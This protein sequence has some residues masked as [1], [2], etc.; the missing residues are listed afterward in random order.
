[1]LLRRNACLLSKMAPTSAVDTGNGLGAI[2]GN[3]AISASIFR[4]AQSAGA[5]TRAAPIVLR[6]TARSAASSDDI[7]YLSQR[8]PTGAARRYCDRRMSA[9][10][11]TVAPIAR[12]VGMLSSDFQA[13]SAAT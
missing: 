9:P 13:G 10:V 4:S 7:G 1:M 6:N 5:Q 3:F 12:V 2:S 11:P 8:L